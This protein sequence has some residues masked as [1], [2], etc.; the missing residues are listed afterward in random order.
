MDHTADAM[1]DS[2]EGEAVGDADEPWEDFDSRNTPFRL[3]FEELTTFAST[4]DTLIPRRD[5][6]HALL[7][8]DTVAAALAADAPVM[9][10]L[11]AKPD[12]YA[13]SETLADIGTAIR[14]DDWARAEARW[15][16]FQSLQQ[17]IDERV[18]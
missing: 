17:K 16:D 10:N 5:A 7:L 13:L 3:A 9:A 11:A 12:I 1:Q 8:I 6:F 18:Y 2:N 15:A 14:A 4:L